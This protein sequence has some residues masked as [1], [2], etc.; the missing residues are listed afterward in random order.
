MICPQCGVLLPENI[1]SCGQCGFAF[2]PSGCTGPVPP[3]PASG[4][5]TGPSPVFG[6]A[7]SGDD[8]TV[9][10]PAQPGPGAALS[11][12]SREQV[13]AQATVFDLPLTPARPA[14]A[15][16][17]G[18]PGTPDPD[19]RPESSPAGRASTPVPAGPRPGPAPG[20]LA[21]GW[22]VALDGPDLGRDFRIGPE[23]PRM[24]IGRTPGPGV[25]DLC[26]E[27]VEEFH[28]LLLFD[29]RE[30]VV[31][32]LDSRGGLRVNGQPVRRSAVADGDEIALGL[33]RLR[34]RA[35]QP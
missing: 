1:A 14:P 5:T 17:S 2:K 21:H 29:G 11:G 35:F 3:G 12:V 30:L 9:F 18:A 34:F 13:T 27:G 33:A 8:P 26:A 6:P 19:Q 4:R 23:H 24:A 25:L 20:G 16:A 31:A 15:E 32:D 28:A 10:V 7:A 22:L